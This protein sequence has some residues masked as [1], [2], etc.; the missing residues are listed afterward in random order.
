M[1][2]TGSSQPT[3]NPVRAIGMA[4]VIWAISIF[5]SRVMGLIREQIIGRTLGASREADL[6]FASFTLPDFL[7]YL[8]AAGALSIVFIPIFLSHLQRDEQERGWEAFSV[9]ANFIILAGCIGIALLMIFARPLASLV[10]PGFTDP[11]EVDTLVR[12]TRII[13]PAQLFHVIGGLLSAV[14]L[15][16]NLHFLPA[17]T[18]LVYS[19]SIIVGGLI[20][21]Q[22]AGLG[23]DG[24][25]WG[26]LVGSVVGPFAL[27]LY[28]CLKINIRWH[29][30][31][32]IRH[33]DLKRYLWL[34]APIMIGFSIVVVDEWIIKNQ[35]SYLGPGALSYLQYG[36]TLMKVPIGI[37]G[38]AAGVAAYPTIS[39][40]VTIGKV[41]E[42][43]ALLCRTIRLMLLLTFAA[44]VCLTLAGF[45]AAYLIWGLFANRFTAADA[46]ATATILSY[47]CLGLSGWAAQSVIS[48]GFYALGS[49]WLPTIVG[50]AVAFAMVPFYVLMRQQLGAIGLAIASALAILMYVIL[51]GWL[52]RRRFEREAANNATSLKDAPRVMNG[53]LRLAVAAA[54]ATGIGLLLRSLLLQLLPGLS[55]AAIVLRSVLLCVFGTGLYLILVRFFAVRELAEIEAMSLRRLKSWHWPHHQI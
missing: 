6:Y 32:S 34:S 3:T 41:A 42:A 11:S 49:T 23:A 30:L 4:S 45:E 5:L 18:S 2:L 33:P 43:Y 35:A 21:S 38:M 36:R 16:Q 47:L 26:A 15:A 10:A 54:V 44:Q 46:Q 50:T 37:F 53:A 40:I 19:A 39:R 31:L 8:L 51:L 29:P 24:F 22:Y 14:L 9:I 48:R 7:N 25:A 28:G 55:F 13:L 52:Q 12:L 27:P 17:M 20:G 1:K